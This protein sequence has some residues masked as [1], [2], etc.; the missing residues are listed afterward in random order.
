MNLI[1]AVSNNWGI[2][3]RGE[4]LFS[5]PED[6]RHFKTLTQNKVV[7]MGHSTFK[8]L[9]NSKALKNRVNIVLSHNINLQID[10]A[11]VY[12]SVEQLLSAVSGFSSEDIFIIGGQA[13]YEQLINYCE[14]AYI[15]KV[16]TRQDADRYF[17]KIEEMSNWKIQCRSSEKSYNDLTYTFV[18]YINDNVLKPAN[19]FK[20]DQ[21]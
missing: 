5:I 21:S 2:G 12:N 16:N 14:F 3:L 15:T 6:M 13:V 9:P 17:P 8:S 18:T 20:S 10:N 7:V 4:L 19:S 1:A 11:M